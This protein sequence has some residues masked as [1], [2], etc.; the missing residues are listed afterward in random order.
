MTVSILMSNETTLVVK[1]M[2]TAPGGQVSFMLT[3][4]DLT[5]IYPGMYR[6]CLSVRSGTRLLRTFRTNTYEYSPGCPLDA[7][8]TCKNKLNEW[9][10]E[11]MDTTSGFQESAK[12]PSKWLP[13]VPH[14]DVI[15]I[16]GSPRGDGNCSTIAGWVADCVHGLHKTVRVLYPD[17]MLIHPCIG[18]YQCYNTGVCTFTDDMGE[19]TEAVANADLIVICSPVYTNTVPGTLKILIDRFIALHAART[20][21][22]GRNGRKAVLVAVSGRK[23]RSNFRCVTSVVHA[24][25]ENTGIICAGDLLLDEMDY[26][27]DVRAVPGIKEK[28]SELIIGVLR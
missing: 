3:R 10:H 24:F 6:Y 18:C 16:Q 23:G 17:D 28:V 5:G 11:I 25:L 13:P 20:L 22:E 8:T 19:V 26:Y 4:E 15:V 21:G 1:R 12:G 27:N 2:V 14:S 9:E 7:E